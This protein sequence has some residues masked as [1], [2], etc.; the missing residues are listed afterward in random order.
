MFFDDLLDDKSLKKIDKKIQKVFN[1]TGVEKKT[2]GEVFD[3]TS[4]K[5]LE[6][7]I[8]DKILNILDFPISTG[9][10]GNVFRGITVDGKFIA[11][12]I[13]RIST[14]TFRHISNYIIGD[15]RFKNFHNKKRDIIFEWTKKEFR[16]LELL[17]KINIPAPKPITFLNNVLVMSYLGNKYSPSPM[18]KNT[19]LKEP[20]EIYKSIINY[21]DIMFT[22]A[23][24]VHSDLSEFN[25]LIHRKKAYIIDLGQGVLL[26][27]PRALDFLKRDIKNIVNFF[28]KYNIYDDYNKIYNQIIN[29]TE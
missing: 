6:K 12:K 20:E 15:P 13:Y 28:R 29:K 18:L 5:S 7:L 9:K 4:L 17:N 1:R 22:K 24:I 25:I 11:V 3:K 10:E 14:S 2:E 21:I 26:Q 8:S 27:H 16:N 23:K 19:I